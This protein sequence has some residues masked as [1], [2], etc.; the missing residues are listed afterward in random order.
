M[1]TAIGYQTMMPIINKEYGLLHLQFPALSGLP[2]VA[3]GVFAGRWTTGRAG[4]GYRLNVGLNC[5]DPAEQVWENRNRMR[6]AL[7][8]RHMVFARQVHGSHVAV[9]PDSS[10]PD[11]DCLQPGCASVDGDAL[12]TANTDC[13]LFIQVADCQP[14]MLVD[15]VKHVLANIHSGWRGSIQ[16]IIGR[17]IQTMADRFGSRAEHIIGAVGPSLGPCCAEFVNYRSEIPE[18]YWAYGLESDHFDFWRIS[19]DQMKAAG[20]KETNIDLSGL[21]TRCNQHL[22]FSYRGEKNAGRFAAVIG[23]MP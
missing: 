18:N 19:V 15:P 3:H 13:A 20:V 14:V 21:C 4:N 1:R 10:V 7:G 17:T 6:I 9:W 22:F 16:N 8:L 2:G 23:W 12:V 5:G 11:S